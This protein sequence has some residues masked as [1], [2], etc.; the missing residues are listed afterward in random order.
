MLVPIL[1]H[2][3][4]IIVL[5][6]PADLAVHPGPRTPHSLE[7]LL[8]EIARSLGSRRL[9]TIM[10]RLD[11]DT[12]GCLLL[13]RTPA[14]VRRIASLFETRQ[15]RKTYWA[16]LDALPEA[17]SGTV[18]RPLAKISSA[19]AGWR[20]VPAPDG[21]HAVT[22]WQVLDRDRRLIEFRP[23]TG[24][25]HQLRVHAN[26]LGTAIQNDPVYGPSAGR[27]GPSGMRLHARSLAIPM[28]D[29]RLVDV[30]AP[31]P[32]NWSEH[33]NEQVTLANHI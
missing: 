1:Y 19:E 13:A 21:K 32:L 29:D 26:C 9:P 5:D 31:L 4:S 14:A 25:T 6:K 8:P 17:D 18:D 28:P 2:D 20:M 27:S 11:R 23:E 15:I 12:S 3:D 33:V 10:H 24:R 30:T 16:L 22:H 7:A